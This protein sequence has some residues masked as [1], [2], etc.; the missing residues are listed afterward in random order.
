MDCSQW[1]PIN[2]GPPMEKLSMEDSHCKPSVENPQWIAVNGRVI[3]GG[4]TM[5]CSQWK[6]INGG[7][8][9]ENSQWRI[10]NGE[11]SMETLNGWLALVGL[12]SNDSS[13]GD[14]LAKVSSQWKGIHG[15]LSMEC[16]SRWSLLSMEDSQWKPL[17]R[18][19]LSMETPSG[20]HICKFPTELI[21]SE[22]H[23]IGNRWTMET[24][25]FCLDLTTFSG[26]H[27]LEYFHGELSGDWFLVGSS[28]W[29]YLGNGQV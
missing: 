20:F 12:I 10:V 11:L 2:G 3:N 28:R 26:G 7:S 5:D 16:G 15:S 24:E 9:M 18:D 21:L 19:W 14:L 17:L 25:R 1:K 23:W 6:P 22:G 27:S 8:S 13:N 4:L 29:R